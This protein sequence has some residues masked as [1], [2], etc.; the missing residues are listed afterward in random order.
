MKTIA[1]IDTTAAGARVDH[2]VIVKII[3]WLFIA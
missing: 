2:G 3:S 1:F